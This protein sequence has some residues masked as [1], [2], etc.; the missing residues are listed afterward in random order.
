MCVHST[1]IDGSMAHGEVVVSSFIKMPGNQTAST[2]IVPSLTLSMSVF[3]VCI[4]IR[5]IYAPV[6]YGVRVN[7]TIVGFSVIKQLIKQLK[8]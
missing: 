6:N 8:H 2:V 3:S 4:K 1:N 7:L 5:C